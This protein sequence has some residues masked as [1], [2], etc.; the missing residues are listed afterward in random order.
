MTNNSA[1]QI[2]EIATLAMSSFADTHGK[3]LVYAEVE[4]GVISSDLFFQQGSS[5]SVQFR[6][7]SKTIQDLIYS[8]WESGYAT[9]A[10]RS[11][12]TMQLVVHDGRFTVDFLYPDQIDPDEDLS[13]R[14]PRVLSVHFPGAPVDYSLAR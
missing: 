12:A 2:Q 10:P 13:D 1:D 8:F 4:P 5:N 11:W 14:R 7:A 3:C 9:I 6:F